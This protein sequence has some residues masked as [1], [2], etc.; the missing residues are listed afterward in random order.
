MTTVKRDANGKM[1]CKDGP[2]VMYHCGRKEWWVCG[3][4]HRIDGPSIEDPYGGGRLN[5]WHISGRRF[6][7]CEFHR[8]VDILSGEAF[9]PP[10]R[11]L[12]HDATPL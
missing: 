4:R 10:G 11:K 1:H 6:T 3:Q 7:E 9:V 12:R 8:Y 2:A 5:E